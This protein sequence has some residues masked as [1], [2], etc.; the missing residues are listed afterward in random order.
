MLPFAVVS[1]LQILIEADNFIVF[2]GREQTQ[3]NGSTDISP[4]LLTAFA[5]IL[6]IINREISSSDTAIC[7]STIAFKASP[8]P[9]DVL[10]VLN[11]TKL[12]LN[13]LQTVRSTHFTFNN[14]SGIGICIYFA[15]LKNKTKLLQ[16]TYI[17]LKNNSQ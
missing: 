8:F 6:N 2:K 9:Q 7:D 17:L 5:F 3:H 15:I 16:P 13:L 1:F 4:I 10:S 12:H 14:C 11:K